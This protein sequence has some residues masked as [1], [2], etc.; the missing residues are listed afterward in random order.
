MRVRG[1]LD[2]HGLSRIRRTG[3]PT[4][5]RNGSAPGSFKTDL[6]VREVSVEEIVAARDQLGDTMW[7]GYLRSAGK[8]DFFHYMA[9]DGAARSRSPRSACSR[10]SAT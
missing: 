5:W 1:W 9:F 4:L 8:E 6:D 7:P 10:T 3:Y 2:A